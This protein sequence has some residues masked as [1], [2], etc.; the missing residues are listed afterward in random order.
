M[1]AYCIFDWSKSMQFQK[2]NGQKIL[3]QGLLD[4]QV[5]CSIL[6]LMDNSSYGLNFI[7]GNKNEIYHH[8]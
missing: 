5:Q 2:P 3:K 4:L 1:H 6:S 8:S 7:L